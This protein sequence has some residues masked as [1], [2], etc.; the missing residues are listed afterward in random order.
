MI[1]VSRAKT[2]AGISI[3]LALV[4]LAALTGCPRGGLVGKGVCLSCHDGRSA[5]DVT[6]FALSPH[7]VL[8]CETCHG[9]GY[10]HVRNGGRGG[11]AIRHP[12]NESFE[13]SHLLCSTCHDAEVDEFLL[14]KHF[15]AR[16][17]TCADC[18]DP[19][20]VASLISA[21][22][23]N[24][25]CLRCHEAL[26]FDSDAAIEAHSFHSVDPAGE[27]GTS[28]CITCHMPPAE[29]ADPAA[30]PPRNQEDVAHGHTLAPKPPIASNNED[31]VRPNSCTGITGCHDGTIRTAPVFDVN[32]PEI[33]E[34]VQIVFDERY[35]Q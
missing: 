32:D 34:S 4:V 5:P 23:D 35:G 26:G 21:P 15:L 31:P 29:L 18:H 7:V 9:P 2:L 30:D 25:I 3:L 28:R 8:E 22:D 17:A 13:R 1:L 27:K 6:E 33:N 19:H 24:S 11:D 12:G 14:S 16:A 10:W 20:K